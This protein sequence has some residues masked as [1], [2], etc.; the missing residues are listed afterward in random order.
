MNHFS[1]FV[2]AGCMVIFKI[3]VSKNPKENR[4]LKAAKF[5]KIYLILKKLLPFFFINIKP[6]IL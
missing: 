3:I 4:K 1:V 5:I 6:L 2:A